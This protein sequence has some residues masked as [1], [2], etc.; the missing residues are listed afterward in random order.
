MLEAV[1]NDPLVR[2]DRVTKVFAAKRFLSLGS[3]QSKTAVSD[4]SLDLHVG[5]TLG[6]VG[7]SG[8]GKSTIGRL[9]LNLLQPCS[10]RICFRGIDHRSRSSSELRALR[11]HMQMVFQNTRGALDPRWSIGSQLREPLDIHRIGTPAERMDRVIEWLRR[12]D[13]EPGLLDRRPAA[14]SGGQRQRVVI[15]RAMMLEPHLV[16]CDE[17]V[18][19]LDLAVQARIISL[20]ERLQTETRTAFLFISHDLRVVRRLAHRVAVM[21]SGKIVEMGPTAAVYS[22]PQHSYTR[23]LLAAAGLAAGAG[24]SR[25]RQVLGAE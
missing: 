10:G 7:E 2:L 22:D 5:E 13:L 12:V 17:P 24:Q 20:F 1:K 15:A 25:A 23:R 11:R 21:K 19:A 9:V 16:V 8:S 6:L 3:Q 18:S 4:V 14:L